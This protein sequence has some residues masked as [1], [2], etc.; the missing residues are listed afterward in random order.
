MRSQHPVS[1]L[2]DAK[3]G[4][5]TWVSNRATANEVKP[6]SQFP[7]IPSGVCSQEPKLTQNASEV[8][9]EKP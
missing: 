7:Q 4:K 9:K 6:L 5:T 8:I 2:P 3:N 1:H